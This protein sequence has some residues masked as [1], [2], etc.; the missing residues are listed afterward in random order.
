MTV[1]SGACKAEQWGLMP[2]NILYAPMKDF[3]L[4]YSFRLAAQS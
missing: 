4:A 2:A 1:S 3:K